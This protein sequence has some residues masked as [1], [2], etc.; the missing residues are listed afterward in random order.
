MDVWS[1]IS[2]LQWTSFHKN[3][4]L[5]S[6]VISRGLTRNVCEVVWTSER[7]GG[8]ELHPQKLIG[9]E[10]FVNYIMVIS[11]GFLDFDIFPCFWSV[12]SSE[13]LFGGCDHPGW[14]YPLAPAPLLCTPLI[15]SDK[16]L[17]LKMKNAWSNFSIETYTLVIWG[18]FSLWDCTSLGCSVIHNFLIGVIDFNKVHF[19][20]KNL[21]LETI[22]NGITKIVAKCKCLFLFCF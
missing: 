20:S 13:G 14:P 11:V 3:L 22:W 15:V 16:T 18:W 21:L 4:Q 8:R 6:E 10:P 19:K 2:S 1:T 12:F 9:F 5:L 17:T 7:I